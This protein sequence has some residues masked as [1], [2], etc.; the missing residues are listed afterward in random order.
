MP[1]FKLNGKNLVHF[2][3]FKNHIGFYPIPSGIKAFKK[4]VSPYK[5]GKGSIQF[6]IDYPVPYDLVDDKDFTVDMVDDYQVLVLQTND[7]ADTTVENKA[8]ILQAISQGTNVLVFTTKSGGGG[9][10]TFVLTFESQA[11]RFMT[12]R[13]VPN[14]CEIPAS[15]ALRTL[16]SPRTESSNNWDSIGCQETFLS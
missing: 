13:P 1:T 11:S 15:T 7:Y 14:N 12:V 5:Q 9:P 10:A 4:E 2:A 8:N 6:R 3:A 16:G